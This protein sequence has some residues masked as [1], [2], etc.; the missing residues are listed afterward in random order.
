MWSTLPPEGRTRCIFSLCSKVLFTKIP[1]AAVW[2]IGWWGRVEAGRLVRWLG[3]PWEKRRGKRGGRKVG[4][5]ALSATD[6][7][8]G[9]SEVPRAVGEAP[10][11]LGQSCGCQAACPSQP[12]FSGDIVKE[13]TQH[14]FLRDCMPPSAV[15]E[16]SSFSISWQHLIDMVEG[17]L[18][19]IFFIFNFFDM[20]HFLKSL[21]NLLQY[22]FWLM[23]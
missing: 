7:L 13:T 2:R 12:V 22:C 3:Y 20:D 9:C 16:S 5:R 18:K 1:W 15:D 10:W 8:V 14:S 21:L 23:F 11:T 6:G 17:S 19:K 4:K